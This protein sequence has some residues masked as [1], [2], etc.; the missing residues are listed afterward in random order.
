MKETSR[1]DLL[2]SLACS[3]VFLSTP[4]AATVCD[5]SRARHNGVSTKSYECKF[6]NDGKLTT[7]FM[8]VTDLLFD[9]AGDMGL[10]TSLGNYES[11]LN[12]HRLIE[13]PLL[14]TLRHLLQNYSFAFEPF[15]VT[16]EF[17]GRANGQTAKA[18]EVIGHT[19][20][21]RTLGVWDDPAPDILPLFP[22]PD[23][24]RRAMD[25]NNRRNES[26]LRYANDQD[27][28]SLDDKIDAYIKLWGSNPDGRLEKASLGNLE[29]LQ[30]IRAGSVDRFLPLIFNGFFGFEDCGG[31]P[32]GGAHY[33]PP[34]LYIDVAVSRNDGGEPVVIEDYFGVVEK[35]ESLRKYT[36]RTPDGAERFGLNSIQLEP[37]NSVMLLQRMLFGALPYSNPDAGLNVKSDRAVFGNTNLPKGV[38]INGENVAFDGRSHNSVI[39]ASYGAR[40]SC[41][42]LHSWC[43]KSQ[44]WVM[45]GKVLTDCVGEENSGQ[46]SRSFCSLRTR[47]KLVE[48]E[49][50][51]TNLH[52]ICL[53]LVLEDH[54]TIMVP[55]ALKRTTLNI[56]E[57][58][59]FSF[60][61][62]EG[63][64]ADDVVACELLIVGYYTKYGERKLQERREALNILRQS[65]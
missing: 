43:D 23:E 49:H 58:Y 39:I 65:A 57:S 20:R 18:A 38:V 15:G 12:G 41:P 6:G 55:H 5:V 45:L 44:E 1:R 11:L 14:A 37:G 30:H 7:T 63:V 47:F 28:G 9:S 33:V 3:S 26:F 21:W 62:P 17:D 48:R 31:Q 22:L 19:R 40:G 24:L 2:V 61:L 46:D 32:A 25:G 13:T 53:K 60:K 10:P 50:E 56:G 27:F 52:S 36:S 64:S 29:L 35:Q 54:T 4:S 16:L 34:A 59:E 8:R 42:Y 51:E